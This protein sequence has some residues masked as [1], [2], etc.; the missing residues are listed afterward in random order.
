LRRNLFAVR[1]QLRA[2]ATGPLRRIARPA[3][4]VLVAGEL[5]GARA[6]GA[7]PDPSIDNVTAIVKTFERPQ[8]AARFVA[9]LRALYPSLPVIVAD[10][11]KHPQPLPGVEQVILP[12]DSGVSAG[13][14]AALDRVATPY[15]LVADDDFVCYRGTRLA[16]ALARLARNPQIDILGGQLIDLPYLRR[17]RP[18]LH[19][20][21]PT[22]AQPLVPIGSTID[23]LLVCDK[24]SNFYLAR[25]DRLRLV[26]WTPELKRIDHADFFTRALGVLVTVFDPSLRALHAQT[27][28]DAHYMAH[29]N[30]DH[31]DRAILAARW[32]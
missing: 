5:A 22:S 4:D 18:P 15:V 19:Q 8:I 1:Q 9:S 13:R 10:D 28:F 32:R 26:G 12:F 20:I 6:L 23:G 24:V 29:R 17:R 7:T 11:S 31:A 16:P 21:F 27:P 3:F 25:T 30:D 14:Q 2:L